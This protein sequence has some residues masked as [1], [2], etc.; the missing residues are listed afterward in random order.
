[1]AAAGEVDEATVIYDTGGID[2]DS[3][4]SPLAL[5]FDG[6]FFFRIFYVEIRR[7]TEC[8]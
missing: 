7:T 4:D 8:N 5:L 6:F 2:G 1:M 3:T